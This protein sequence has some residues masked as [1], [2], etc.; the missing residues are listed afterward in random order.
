MHSEMHP[1]WQNPIQ[2]TVRTAH[3]S[4]LMIV[5]NCR[6]QYSNGGRVHWLGL[7]PTWHKAGHYGVAKFIN[8][9]S[10]VSARQLAGQYRRELCR[11]STW[12]TVKWLGKLI[13]YNTSHYH[14]TDLSQTDSHNGL[15]ITQYN[16]PVQKLESSKLQDWKAAWLA[17]WWQ[18]TLVV[19]VRWVYQWDKHS[20]CAGAM[21]TSDLQYNNLMTNVAKVLFRNRLQ[22]TQRPLNLCLCVWVCVCVCVWVCVRV[23]VCDVPILWDHDTVMFLEDVKMVPWHAAVCLQLDEVT[24]QV[25]PVNLTHNNRLRHLHL[26][27][28]IML[29]LP[30]PVDSSKSMD[31]SRE[32]GD[33]T[34]AHRVTE[35][36]SE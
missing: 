22:P 34:L 1:V 17:W 11:A 36:M 14:T 12:P 24:G 32:V 27:A 20:L 29:A 21:A 15:S 2:R 3:L 28:A 33:V 16:C 31:K 7:R 13:N 6:I 26:H 18:C 9:S 10:L 35:P 4:V 8:G 19:G 23:C 5:H 30:C 25:V